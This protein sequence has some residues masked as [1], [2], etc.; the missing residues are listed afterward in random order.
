MEF[1]NTAKRRCFAYDVSQSLLELALKLRKAEARVNGRTLRTA[2]PPCSILSGVSSTVDG[3]RFQFIARRNNIVVTTQSKKLSQPNRAGPSLWPFLSSIKASVDAEHFRFLGKNRRFYSKYDKSR[4]VEGYVEPLSE[5]DFEFIID[6]AIDT[7]LQPRESHV[8]Q[9]LQSSR[10]ESSE[11]AAVSV[12]PLSMNTVPAAAS[13]APL[14]LP[15]IVPLSMNT[16]INVPSTLPSTLET[17]SISTTPTQPA[18][19]SKRYAAAVANP[20]R[21]RCE[22]CPYST[23]NRSHVRRHHISVHSD[24]R[25]YRCFICGKEFARCENAKVHMVSR[26][27]DVPYSVDRLRNNMFYLKPSNQLQPQPTNMDSTPSTS[28]QSS[29]MSGPN[30]AFQLQHDVGSCGTASQWPSRTSGLEHHQVISPWLGLPKI[31]PKPDQNMP[32]FGHGN[33]GNRLLEGI[34]HTVFQGPATPVLNV[35]S[36][37]QSLGTVKQ[38]PA[39]TKPACYPLPDRHVC[40]YCQ[41]VCQNAAELATHI[42]TSHSSPAPALCATPNSNPGYVVLQTAAPIFLFPYGPDSV[43]QNRSQVGLGYHPILPKLPTFSDECRSQNEVSAGENSSSVA[44]ST[45]HGP[46]QNVPNTKAAS[47]DGSST[48]KIKGESFMPET[49][50]ES[51]SPLSTPASSETKRERKRQFKTFYCNRCPDRA[52]FRY[53][54]SFEKH[55]KQH[56]FE[57]R[58]QRAQ[59]IASKVA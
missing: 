4:I 25:P 38:E 50:Q 21:F 16:N 11:P 52:P 58:S 10:N 24:A 27:P 3:G 54:K 20:R 15:V 8:P 57:D 53:E 5:S 51:E 28:T 13:V 34:P 9:Q 36:L 33:T 56:R 22:L 59:K 49:G 45:T 32:M 7:V 35:Q 23:N 12:E 46:S 42:A 41:F 40:L 1:G 55:V 30:T 43:L 2:V 47:V 17:D 29:N 48:P 37:Y 14:P 39:D 6:S 26:H 44:T 31:E 19:V 18:V